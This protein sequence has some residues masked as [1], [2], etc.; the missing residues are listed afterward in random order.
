MNDVEFKTDYRIKNVINLIKKRFSCDQIL[1]AGY[2]ETEL[3][4]AHAILERG[5]ND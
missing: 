5:K 2:T 4:F 1:A 3:I